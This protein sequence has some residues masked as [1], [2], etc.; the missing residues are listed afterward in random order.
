MQRD[1]RDQLL[2]RSVPEHGVHSREG[3]ACLPV[4][5]EVLADAGGEIGNK[6]RVVESL[7]IV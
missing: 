1:W 5:G 7:Q 4:V 6:K 3:D 2:W